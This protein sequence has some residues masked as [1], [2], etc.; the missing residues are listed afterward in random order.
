MELSC[1]LDLRR[2]CLHARWTPRLQNEEAD[3]L[4]NGDFQ[5]FDPALRIPVDLD[6]LDSRVLNELS[7]IGEE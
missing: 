7:E 2:A 5:H 6:Q 1:Q 3:V 4:T